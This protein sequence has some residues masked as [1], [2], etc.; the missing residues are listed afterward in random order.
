MLDLLTPLHTP[1]P[2]FPCSLSFTTLLIHLPLP[3]LTL[4][5]P[6]HSEPFSYLP[7]F[8]STQSF[9]S[10]YSH[11]SSLTSLP[12]LTPPFTHSSPLTPS[13]T[14]PLSLF[15]T[16]THLSLTHSPFLLTYPFLIYFPPLLNPPTYSSFSTYP[17][18]THPHLF[19]PPPAHLI[20]LS[21]HFPPHLLTLHSLS[22]TPLPPIHS[23]FSHS[24]S[25][26]SPSLYSPS[27]I[28]SFIHSPALHSLSLP[29]FTHPPPSTSH[30]FNSLS[31][32]VFTQSIATH[33][34]KVSS[35]YSAL[36][37]HSNLP[38]FTFTNRLYQQFNSY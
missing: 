14:H 23:L 15:F 29:P 19:T 37:K 10:P 38:N 4:H 24:P 31:L 21:I 13:L 5:L 7:K 27:P 25:P 26:Y 30:S 32:I 16:F 1:S 17:L 12:Y 34:I 33:A 35:F 22:L 36:S 6:T 3:S 8:S 28:F 9:P 11:L 2:P 20:P 18:P